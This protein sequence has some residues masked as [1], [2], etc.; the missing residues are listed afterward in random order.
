M[1]YECSSLRR[2][3]KFDGDDHRNVSQEYPHITVHCQCSL[4]ALNGQYVNI[5]A[6]EGSL[7]HSLR[8]RFYAAHFRDHAFHVRPTGNKAVI[9]LLLYLALR[10]VADAVLQPLALVLVLLW[11]WPRHTLFP[12]PRVIFPSCLTSFLAKQKTVCLLCRVNG[13]GGQYSVLASLGRCKRKADVPFRRG[14]RD[15]RKA[16]QGGAGC[17]CRPLNTAEIQ[18]RRPSR[19]ARPAPFTERSDANGPGFRKSG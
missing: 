3:N 6:K 2:R 16:A 13:Q 18:Q 19:Q 5:P 17:Q 10:I 15:S 4:S 9:S 1:S 11:R 7:R 12:F 14:R 8:E